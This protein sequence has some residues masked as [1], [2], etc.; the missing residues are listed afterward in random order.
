MLKHIDIVELPWPFF[1][2]IFLW[3]IYE[4]TLFVQAG[5]IV[6]LLMKLSGQMTPND[7]GVTDKY[8]YG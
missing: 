5:L 6:K 8:T 4:N 1:W 7:K 2:I 3:M